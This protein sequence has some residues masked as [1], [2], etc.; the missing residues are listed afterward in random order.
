MSS[1][2]EVLRLEIFRDG[3]K[4]VLKMDCDDALMAEVFREHLYDAIT[5]VGAELQL[6]MKTEDV[7]QGT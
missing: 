6:K 3:T 2:I 1:V 7:G 4:V 5:T